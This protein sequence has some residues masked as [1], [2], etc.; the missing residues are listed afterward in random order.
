MLLALAAAAASLFPPA[1]PP[2]P[3]QLVVLIVVDQ[4]RPDYFT[5]FAGQLGGGLARL[6]RCGDVF[7]NGITAR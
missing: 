6:R 4:L 1:P 7:P 3:P 5:R 2:P